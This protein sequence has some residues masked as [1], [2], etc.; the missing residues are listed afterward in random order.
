M[1]NAENVTARGGD[2]NDVIDT[3]KESQAGYVVQADG[4]AGA[5]HMEHEISP[6]LVGGLGGG[7][8][9]IGGADADRFE[10]RF[11]AGT[12]D[13]DATTPADVVTGQIATIQDFTPGEDFLSIQPQLTQEGYTLGQTRIDEDPAQGQTVLTVRF[14]HAEHAAHEMTVILKAVGVQPS[15]YEIVQPS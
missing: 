12:S 4:G 8:M 7:M 1:R 3:G 6:N 13:D 11:D 15:D 2:G 10:L 5:D 14:D 9:M